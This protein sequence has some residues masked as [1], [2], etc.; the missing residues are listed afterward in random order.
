MRV[1]ISERKYELLKIFKPYLFYKDGETY[2]KEEAP[3]NAKEAFNEFI[4][5]PDEPEAY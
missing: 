5:I 1:A 4:T 3:Q 2:I